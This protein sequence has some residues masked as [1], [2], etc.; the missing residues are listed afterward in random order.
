MDI[1]CEKARNPFAGSFLKSLSDVSFNRKQAIWE[2]SAS[3]SP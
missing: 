2:R 1:R 3:L